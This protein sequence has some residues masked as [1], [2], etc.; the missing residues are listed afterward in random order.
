MATMQCQRCKETKDETEFH[1][2]WKDIERLKICK[3]CRKAD[4]KKYRDGSLDKRLEY[5][6]KYVTA[7]RDNFISYL[8][9][10]YCTHKAE[11][12]AYIDRNID[13]ISDRGTRYYHANKDHLREN[14]QRWSKANKDK[15]NH[16]KKKRDAKKRGAEMVDFTDDQWI[17]LLREHDSTCA[18]CGIAGIPMEQDHIHPVSL[19]G[20]HTKSN[21]VPSCKSCNSSKKNRTLEQWKRTLYFRTNCSKSKI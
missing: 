1:W 8:R 10:Y 14:K 21:I 2:K 11:R 18:Y 16:Y 19:G 12:A 9:N 17:E 6:R 4:S 7:H 15:E 5:N 13:K 3:E 20:N